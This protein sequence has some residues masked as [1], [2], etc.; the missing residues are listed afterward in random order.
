MSLDL[1]T[2]LGV[3]ALMQQSSSEAEWNDNCD[4]V[5]AANGG[6]YPQFWFSTIVLSGVM[7]STVSKFKRS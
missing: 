2:P 6:D 1:S 5:K 3:K 4:K 7:S